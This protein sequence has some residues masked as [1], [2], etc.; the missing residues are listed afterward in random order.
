MPPL[1]LVRHGECDWNRKK[2]L[3]DLDRPLTEKGKEQAESAA[4][5]LKDKDISVIFSSPLERALDTARR[6]HAYHPGIEI[7]V[8]PEFKERHHGPLQHEDRQNVPQYDEVRRS[9]TAKLI[10]GESFADVETRVVPALRRV[11]AR[12]ERRGVVITSH[13]DVMQTMTRYLTNVSVEDMLKLRFENG[14]VY[15][16]KVNAIH[17]YHMHSDFSDGK[18]SIDLMVAAAKSAGFQEIAITDHYSPL[19]VRVCKE[20]RKVKHQIYPEQMG[21]YFRQCSEAEQK[22]QIRVLKG[23]ELGYIEPDEKELR[24]TIAQNQPD[25][26]LVSVH[27]LELLEDLELAGKTEMKGYSM[28]LTGEIFNELVRQYGSMERIYKAY[29]KRIQNALNAGFQDSCGKVGIGHLDVFRDSRHYDGDEIGPFIEQCVEKIA[30]Q[31]ISLEMNFHPNRYASK[32]EPTPGYEAAKRFLEFGGKEVWFGSD[33]HCVE[34]LFV[35]A[36]YH[37]S[38]IR[39]LRR[40]SEDSGG[41]K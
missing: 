41:L 21:E 20:R 17:D 9:Y 14:G 32:G 30:Q 31:G 16:H 12:N 5:K 34:Q 33:S 23:L 28:Y 18:N 37:P 36:T 4:Q 26:I 10:G 40:I 24:Q 39:H 6:I 27:H 8:V 22:H 13:H 25:I 1:Y 29:F 3:G 38:F 2:V 19:L 11:L 7:I 15:A 35:A